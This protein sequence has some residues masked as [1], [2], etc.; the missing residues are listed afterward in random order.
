MS[1]KR[2]L[3]R[4]FIHPT[5]LR[6]KKGKLF[7]VYLFGMLPSFIDEIHATIKA[8][9]ATAKP[10]MIEAYGELYFKAWKAATGPYLVKIGKIGQSCNCMTLSFLSEHSCI[11]ELMNYGIHLENSK[12]TAAIRQILNAFHTQ[13]KTK[14]VDE[15]LLRLYEPILWRSLKVA[16]PTGTHESPFSTLSN[17]PK[18]VFRSSSKK[19]FRFVF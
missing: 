2:M 5:F 18:L 15:M 8:Q 13:K 10:F 12:I 4:T 1:L 11:Q 19:C 7:L 9:L 16:N 17:Q 14:G 6:N 3:L